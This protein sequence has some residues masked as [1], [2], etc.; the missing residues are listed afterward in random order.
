MPLKKAKG[1]ELDVI[2]FQRFQEVVDKALEEALKTL[3]VENFESCFPN[4]ANTFTGK[5]YLQLSQKQIFEF[6][7]NES[8]KEFE[9]IYTER[10]LE[11]K[12]T[13]L[14]HLI[15]EARVS[16]YNKSEDSKILVSDLSPQDIMNARLAAVKMAKVEEYQQHLLE[17]K[18]Q[19]E[20]DQLE[21][22]K[23]LTESNDL[24][25]KINSSISDH[26][27]GIELESAQYEDI[28]SK[29]KQLLPLQ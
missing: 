1:P 11:K 5:K 20:L 12:L 10:D 13:L 3:S 26:F 24:M 2:R 28:N 9:L 21:L 4:I 17:L 6:W 8:K 25:N 16:K 14:D 15:Y 23:I 19:N 29:I 22:N 18:K 7:K 27:D